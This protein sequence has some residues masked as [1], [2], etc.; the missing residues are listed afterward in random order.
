[1]TI[2]EHIKHLFELAYDVADATG[3]EFYDCWD[4]IE[5]GLKEYG[6]QS[7]FDWYNDLPEISKEREQFIT[8]AIDKYIREQM[9]PIY[10]M[11]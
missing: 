5:M 7:Y 11:I 1:M 4:D 6:S 8:K 9:K 3:N 2:K 10:N